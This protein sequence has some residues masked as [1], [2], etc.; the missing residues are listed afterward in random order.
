MRRILGDHVEFLRQYRRRFETT[1]AIAPSSRFLAR[2]LARPLERHTGPARVLEVG[3]GTGAVTQRL[4]RLLKPDDRLDCVELNEKFVEVL[5]HKQ[6]SDPD[7]RR[8]AD[9]MAI[10][11]CPIQEFQADAPYDF[12]VSGLPFNNFPPALV[13][14]IFAV[15]FRLLAPRGVLSYFEYMYMRPL[16]RMVSNSAGKQRLDALEGVLQGYL[17]THRIRR[18]WIFVNIPPAWVQHLQAAEANGSH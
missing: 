17:R 8:V 5:R 15:F 11:Q 4:V 10:H 14:E 18:D 6:T 16:R 3:P 7:Y 9:R 13:S 1:G 12:I 2:A